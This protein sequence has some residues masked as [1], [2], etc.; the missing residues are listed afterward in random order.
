MVEE[1]E[2]S[3]IKLAQSERK[4]WREMAKQVAHEIKTVD[5]NAHCKASKENLIGDPEII[6]KMKDYSETLIQQIDTMNAVASAFSNFA[7]MPASK[8][9]R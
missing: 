5:P 9:K 8:T 7:S 3:A 1:L 2:I 6:Q 4:N